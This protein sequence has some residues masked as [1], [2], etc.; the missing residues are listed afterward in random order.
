M[1]WCNLLSRCRKHFLCS[2][3]ATH[4]HTH[5]HTHGCA[6]RRFNE[7]ELKMTTLIAAG[8]IK[9]LEVKKRKKPILYQYIC[10]T[11][12]KWNVIQSARAEV[13]QP[14]VT[15]VTQARHDRE[16]SLNQRRRYAVCL[17]FRPSRQEDNVSM[18]GSFILYQ[19]SE[20]SFF[21][22]WTSEIWYMTDFINIPANSWGMKKVTMWVEGG[23]RDFFCFVAATTTWFD[24][25]SKPFELRCFHCPDLKS[26]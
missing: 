16:T 1:F 15:T 3:S 23:A 19:L 8:A 26:K 21:I 14:P 2:L 9:H 25:T 18:S 22:S 13:S 20:M 10:S 4:T 24:E 11:S 5:T 6:R 12:T 17:F 7:V